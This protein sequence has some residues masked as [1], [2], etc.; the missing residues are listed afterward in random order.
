MYVCM[1]VQY[2]IL[3][4]WEDGGWEGDEGGGGCEERRGVELRREGW[5]V[6]EGG[7]GS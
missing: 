1:Y 6:E 3:M 5:G 2:K 4:A 7:L